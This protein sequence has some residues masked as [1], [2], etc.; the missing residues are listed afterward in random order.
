M[1]W[2]VIVGHLLGGGVA[3]LLAL[4]CGREFPCLFSRHVLQAIYS[5]ASPCVTI[6]PKLPFRETTSRV[7]L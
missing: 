7:L 6:F 3:T 2:L 4:R 5:H 1:N